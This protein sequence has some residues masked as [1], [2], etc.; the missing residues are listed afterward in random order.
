[1]NSVRATNKYG[2]LFN[3]G[4][5]ATLNALRCPNLV[6]YKS[7]RGGTGDY[8]ERNER[9]FRESDEFKPLRELLKRQI[10]SAYSKI[11]SVNPNC[12]PQ[13]FPY[14][15]EMNDPAYVK[16][17][18]DA[19]ALCPP[20]QNLS[21]VPSLRSYFSSSTL[22]SQWASAQKIFLDAEVEKIEEE[23]V[24]AL[25]D[26]GET[27]EGEVEEIIP[28]KDFSVSISKSL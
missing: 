2:S 15:V 13:D 8:A 1:L 9:I 19:T 26:D 21:Q 3:L 23:W 18:K 24:K 11:L 5:F 20:L 25:E 12:S 27:S 4:S 10:R 17:V 14:S 6:P 7:L 28:S 22:G 16:L